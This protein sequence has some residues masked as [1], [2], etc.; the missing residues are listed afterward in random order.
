MHL[1]IRFNLSCSIRESLIDQVTLATVG[2]LFPIWR[3]QLDLTRRDFP[4]FHLHTSVVF[5]FGGEVNPAVWQERSFHKSRL[6]SEDYFAI[7]LTIPKGVFLKAFVSGPRKRE[8]MAR[9]FSKGEVP[10]RL[11]SIQTGESI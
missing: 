4:P 10:I 6:F 3:F 9:I 1:T 8:G 2:Q 7:F 11:L 5:T